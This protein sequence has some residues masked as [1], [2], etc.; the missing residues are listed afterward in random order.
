MDII[1]RL[2]RRRALAAIGKPT[3][4]KQSHISRHPARVLMLSFLAPILLGTLLLMLPQ[5]TAAGSI[6]FV[7]ALFT[8]TSATCVTGLVVMDTGAAFTKFGQLVILMLIQLGGLGIMT[9]ATFF[10]YL[11][12]GRIGAMERDIVQDTLSQHSAADMARLLKVVLFFTV[13]IEAFGCG[14]LTLRFA[15]DFPL[16]RAFYLGLFHSIS[17]FCNA[18]FG[19]FANSLESYRG[20]LFINLIMMGLIVIGGLG[21][22]VI[23]DLFHNRRN[24][25][26][27]YFMKLR[28]HTRLVL[29]VSGLLIILG[30]IVIFVFEYQNTLH[31][32]SL[33]EK[34]L[35][36]VFQSV[37][38]RTAGFNTL[39]IG[40]L[41]SAAL[42]FIMIL[43]FIGA[44]PASCGGGIKTSTF[45]VLVASITA[46]YRMEED[47]NIFHRRIPTAIVSRAIS[48][49]FF[50]GLI[51]I[52]FT[53]AI[54]ITQ[55]TG[56]SPTET[57]GMFLDY[58]FEVVSAFATVGLSAGGTAELNDLGKLLITLLM[59]VGRL[60]PLTIALAVRGSE[61]RARFKYV[62][63]ET[64]VG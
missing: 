56:L 14:L 4:P 48:V 17:A 15:Q 1:Y 39:P 35:A 51:V 33:G 36:A 22:I 44:S 11:L 23:Y 47:A 26:R 8:A 10:I 41:S 64:L 5:A 32:L 60:G 29:F 25:G 31:D 42:F 50:S 12:A 49:V 13:V 45:A 30:A 55:L 16:Q 18:G 3:P 24:I 46:R 28:F 57:R 52:V 38:A 61:T 2:R 43:M 34:L 37:T 63:E 27:R 20:D 9:L 40:A 6:S 53:M 54:L 58:L 21:F 59:F 62:Q 7:N 19:L